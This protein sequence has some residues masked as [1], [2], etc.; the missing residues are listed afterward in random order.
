MRKLDEEHRRFFRS[1]EVGQWKSGLSPEVLSALAAEPY[2]SQLAELGYSPNTQ[3]DTR[4]PEALPA[5]NPFRRSPV[6]ANGAI[7]APII[8][9]CY[10]SLDPAR[11]ARWPPVGDVGRGSFFAWLNEPSELRGQGLYAGVPLSRLAH[12]IYRDRP[13]LERAF[14]DLTGSDRL[15]YVQWF[16]R[17][18]AETPLKLDPRFITPLEEDLSRWASSRFA[19]DRMR[20]PWWPKLTNFTIHIYRSVPKLQLDY[21]DYLVKDRWNLL[22][23]LAY[24]HNVEPEMPGFKDWIRTD[25]ERCAKLRS[26]IGSFGL[27]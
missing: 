2:R 8:E 1:G 11:N 13:D 16:V 9:A 20:R 17:Y 26:A 22:H 15:G 18:A 25:L 4:T 6:F 23:W 10:L 14:P 5:R 24:S 21:P 7:V 27:S 19:E 12:Y 3:E